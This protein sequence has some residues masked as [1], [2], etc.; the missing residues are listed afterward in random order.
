MTAEYRGQADVVKWVGAHSPSVVSN[1]IKRM[2]DEIPQPDAIIVNE[3]GAQPTRGWLPERK[4]E[5]IEFA[6]KRNTAVA[7]SKSAN[8]RRTRATAALIEQGVKAGTI[9]PAE[10]VKLLAELI[11]R[12]EDGKP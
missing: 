2:P 12:P 10:A 6:A 8:A 4:P 3:G 5:W 1:W 7:E 11:G 9:D